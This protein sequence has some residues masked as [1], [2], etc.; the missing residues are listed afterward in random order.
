M[1][2]ISVALLALLAVIP[3]ILCDAVLCDAATFYVGP[4]GSDS[5]GRNQAT[6]RST[7]WRSIQRGVNEAGGGD[8]VVVLSGTYYES[9][10][11]GRSGYGGN[12]IT[13]KSESREG[14]RLIGSISSNDQSY[15]RVDGFDVSNYSSTGLTK[16]ISF[17]RCHHVTVRDCRVRECWGGGISFDQTD[18]ILCEWNITHENAY[19]DPNQHSGISVYQPQYRGNDSRAYGIIIRNN[20]S[21]NNWN[22]VNNVN[23][24]RPTDGN[25]IVVDDFKNGQSGGNGVPYDRMTVIENNICFDNGGQGIHCY[26]SQNIRIRNNTCVNNVGSFDFGGEV[27]VS[28]SER[29]Y[30][31]NNILTAR[32]G[33][34]A[35]LQ[36][37]SNNFW[38]GFNVIDG[39]V[40]NVPYD[41]SNIYGPAGFRQGS[42]ELEPFSAAVNSGVDGGDH[43]FLD[44][45]GQNRQNAALDRGAIEVQ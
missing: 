29:V 33:K 19:N 28:E 31:Y 42:F 16:G 17:N 18:W 30:V 7:P 5:Y 39:P 12:E 3:A 41:G 13:L 24:G 45:Y 14:A 9:V 43:F 2:R 15:L 8:T 34:R 44:A 10:Y 20:T 35:A 26:A 11:L 4:N 21:F 37:D 27:S 6:N 22:Y 25:G 36:Y 38:F 40:L 23:F 32:N 1:T